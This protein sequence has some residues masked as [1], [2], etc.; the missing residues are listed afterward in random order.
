MR[1]N[2]DGDRVSEWGVD[3]GVFYPNAG[4]GVPWNGLSAVQ[5]QTSESNY[6]SR[7]IDGVKTRQRQSDGQFSGVIETFTYPDAFHDDI[8]VQTRPK[9]F[10]LSY[11]VGAGDYYRIHLVYNVVISPSDVTH[12]QR[13]IDRFSW[14]FTTTPVQVPFAKPT[15]H[16]IVDGVTGYSWMLADLEEI[17][18]GNASEDP[19]L[20]TPQEVW[21]VVEQA[22]LLL[23]VDHGDGTFSVIGPDSA[24]TMLSATTFEIDWPSVI[25]LDPNTYQISSL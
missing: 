24:I 19:R 25:I 6:R 9:S 22:S 8:L 20:P 2:W 23:V 14:A 11:R 10:G 17:L 1:I 15:A 7:Y 12:Q 21:D 18:Y 16:L 3:R 4:P 5:E 13:E